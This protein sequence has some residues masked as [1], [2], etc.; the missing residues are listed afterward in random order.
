M[1]H[2]QTFDATPTTSGADAGRVADS[3]ERWVGLSALAV[4]MVAG[5]AAVLL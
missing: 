3:L 5:V 4:V 1:H 2:R